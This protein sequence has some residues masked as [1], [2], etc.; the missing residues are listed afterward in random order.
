MMDSSVDRSIALSVFDQLRFMRTYTQILLCFPLG[1]GVEVTGA[2]QRA[3]AALM[4]AIPILAGQVVNRKNDTSDVPS[5]RT[6]RVAPYRHPSGS[7]VQVKIL[8][9]FMWYEELRAA[10]TPPSMLDA[11]VLAPQRGLMIRIGENLSPEDL[12]VMNFDRGHLPVALKP[13]Q[14]SMPHPEVAAKADQPKSGASASPPA[15]VWSYISIPDAKLKEL[16][17]Q[18]L[19]DPSP[20]I[21]WVSTNDAVVA[22][23][24]RVISKV[25]SSRTDPEKSTKLLRAISGCRVLDPKLP[26]TYVGNV[27]VCAFLKANLKDLEEQSLSQ[28]AQDV[29]KAA[30]GIDDHYVRSFA[31]LITAEPDRNKITFAMD[32]AH[33]DLLFSSRAALPVYEGFGSIIGA[34][35][36]VRRPTS[37][38][39]IG[40]SY[41]MPKRPYGSLELAVALREDEMLNLRNNEQFAA[42]ADYIG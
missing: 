31:A 3:A 7:P 25:R 17:A 34:P 6:F 16:K 13:N 38:P 10:K 5:S 39:W 2:L 12:Q 33:L 21:R 8:D 20:G 36:Y 28:T 41:V 1:P 42:V 15:S 27:V 4:E 40:V 23:L 37:S 22:W 35:D 14:S 26:K 19:R 29:R 9:D 18:S 24:W 32:D 11:K 30:N